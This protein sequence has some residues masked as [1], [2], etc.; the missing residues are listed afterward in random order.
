MEQYDIIIAGGGPIGS[1]VG[2]WCAKAG[3]TVAIIEEHETVGSP[4]HC[5]GL[6]TEPRVLHPGPPQ[7]DLVLNTITGAEIHSPAG[8]IVTIGGDRTHAL[9]ID[10]IRYDRPSLKKPP[11]RAPLS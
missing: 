3:R 6:V 4:L 10:R 5:A 2:R 9:V 8:S 7:D 11:M 1:A